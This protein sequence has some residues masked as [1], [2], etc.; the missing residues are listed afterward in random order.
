MKK[1]KLQIAILI[2]V[3]ITTFSCSN[4]SEKLESALNF[5][6][7]NRVELERVLDHFSQNEG[8]SLKYRAAVFL[9]E[10][11]KYH[12][13]V[14]GEQIDIYLDFFD[15][16]FKSDIE[17]LALQA[18]LDSL[19]VPVVNRSDVS[20]Q[21]DVK[22]M[23]AKYLIDYID[24]SF[25]VFDFPWCKDLSFNDFCEYVLPYRVANEPL[26]EWRDT[27]L[28]LHKTKIDSFVDNNFTAQQ[29]CEYLAVN[30]HDFVY[31]ATSPYVKLSPAVLSQI[32]VGACYD[33]AI[34]G[35]YLMRSFGLPVTC[36]FTP[37]WR[38]RLS[39]HNWNT[40]LKK[41]E[42]FIPFLPC[43]PKTFGEHFKSN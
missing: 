19:D 1:I 37:H 15:E 9:I 25:E 14:T 12:Y 22:V 31:Y 33:Y 6:G 5:A 36:D 16:L 24:K 34:M 35:T 30:Y 40:L 8:D 32:K 39:D 18:K 23:T 29:L 38:Y 11:M 13:S 2:V 41:D 26:E 21:F 28:D 20:Y 10:N 17:P 42:T 3:A 27:Y 4:Q 43:D 7:E